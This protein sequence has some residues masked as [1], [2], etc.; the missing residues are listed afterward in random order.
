M[1]KSFIDHL[2][3]I[4]KT[5]EGITKEGIINKIK[6]SIIISDNEIIKII[7]EIKDKF[8][9]EE[10]KYGISEHDFK[11]ELFDDDDDDDD[12]DNVNRYDFIEKMNASYIVKLIYIY[13]NF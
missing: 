10:I 11:T 13:Q 8:K 9:G 6:E 5:V 12:D 3:D 7:N 2:R 4:I 1:E